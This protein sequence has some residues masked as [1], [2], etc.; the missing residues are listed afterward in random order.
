MI[1]DQGGLVERENRS[2]AGRLTVVC[3]EVPYPPNHGGKLDL[4]NLI[5][6]LHNQGLSL[7]LVCWFRRE[8]IAP[9]VRRALMTVA[10]DI[11]EVSRRDGWWRLLFSRYP[12]RMLSFTPSRRDHE[13]LRQRVEA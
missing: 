11:V 7:Q 13:M 6:G 3:Q 10:D 2:S 1:Q 8:H 4:W 12:P 5:R 9:N